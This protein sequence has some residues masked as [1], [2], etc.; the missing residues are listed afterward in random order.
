MRSPKTKTKR[1]RREASIERL[2]DAAQ[3]LFVSQGYRQTNLDQIAAAAGLTKGA[4]YFYF[5]S[6]ETVLIE[7]L[8]RVQAIVVDDAL[9]VAAG[10]GPR[11]T[12]KLV[13]FLHHQSKLGVTH[14]DAVL[15]LVLMS[16]EFSER[17]GAVR[18]LLRRVYR[19]LYRFVEGLIRDGQR[20]GEIRA[21]ARCRELSAIVMAIHDGT[22]L[23]WYRRSPALSGPELVRALRSVLLTGVAGRPSL[24]G[25]ARR[26][27][28]QAA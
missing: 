5:R 22:F 24:S 19:R 25:V 21:D 17:E 3:R 23:E 12:D 13:A 2:L 6:K 14:R 16:L 10:A 7:L 4:V 11:A 28:L 26:A 15:L 20:S 1:A 8:G 27:R 9:K 18:N